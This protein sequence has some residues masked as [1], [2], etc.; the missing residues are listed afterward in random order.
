MARGGLLPPPSPTRGGALAN[1]VLQLQA[2]G[3]ECPWTDLALVGALQ[4]HGADPKMWESPG[5]TLVPRE[6]SLCC[7]HRAGAGWAQGVAG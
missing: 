4:P 1:V 3:T 7:T 5:T 2:L 6:G